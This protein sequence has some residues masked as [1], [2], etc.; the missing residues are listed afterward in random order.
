VRVSAR[1]F[2]RG[3]TLIKKHERRHYPAGIVITL[4]TGAPVLIQMLR[5]IARRF[6][7]FFAESGSA[8]LHGMRG[9]WCSLCTAI[10]VATPKKPALGSDATL[11]LSDPLMGSVATVAGCTQGGWS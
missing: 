9:L 2:R 8:S 3:G 5:G 7:L 11:V 1:A 4:A 6:V 10:P